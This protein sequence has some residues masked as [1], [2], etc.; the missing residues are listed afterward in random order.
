MN[1]TRGVVAAAALVV[2]AGAVY[3][4]PTLKFIDTDAW[5]PGSAGGPFEVFASGINAKGT[6]LHGAAAGNFITFCV[7]R[8][9]NISNGQTY[10]AKINTAAVKGG[11]SGSIGGSDPLDYETAYLYT[12][13]MKGTLSAELSAFDGSVFAYQSEPSGS[14]L[15]DAIWYS[16]GEISL[17]TLNSNA[18]AKSLYDLAVSKVAGDW[19]NTI[20][21][22]RILNLTKNGQDRQDQ[23]VII[24]L[25]GAAG[26]GLAG[27][28]LVGIRRRR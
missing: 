22:V 28:A 18:L 12:S 13:F 11:V 19:G 10:D 23:L 24:P 14:A 4:G 27:L 21:N 8:N 15:Q 2:S 16:E 1:R 3:A 6:G 25:P 17:T 20:G 26:M 7:E 5:G 9:E